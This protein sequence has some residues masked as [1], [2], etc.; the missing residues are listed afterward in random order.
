MWRNYF[1]GRGLAD[2]MRGKLSPREENVKPMGD[3][4]GTPV[5]HFVCINKKGILTDAFLN[6]LS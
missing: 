4:D 6:L 2:S 1:Y 3:D 5:S